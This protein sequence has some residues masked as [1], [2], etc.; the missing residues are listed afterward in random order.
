L[1]GRDAIR[2]GLVQ[3]LR[4]EHIGE[5]CI[6]AQADVRAVGGVAL[7]EHRAGGFDAQLVVESQAALRGGR[8]RV[9]DALLA[10]PLIGQADQAECLTDRLLA[11]NARYLPWA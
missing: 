2:A 6:E 3:S 7:L 1:Q 4:I 10:H 8:G 5:V 11:E 9:Y